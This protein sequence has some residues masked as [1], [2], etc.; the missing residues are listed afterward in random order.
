MIW[1][2]VILAGLAG[3]WGL[4]R[5]FTRESGPRRRAEAQGGSDFYVTDTSS[6]SITPFAFGSPD[7]PPYDSSNASCDTDSAGSGGWDSGGDSGSC[8]SGGGD[9][10]GGG[11]GGG[12]G[13]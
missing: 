2:V 1:V 6:S 9:S 10:G 13:D 3:T 11:D 5:L 12:G 7:T 4:A 8:D